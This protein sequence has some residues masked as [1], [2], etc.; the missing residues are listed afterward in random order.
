VSERA[1]CVGCWEWRE[2]R[3]SRTVWLGE[4]DCVLCSDCEEL[5]GPRVAEIL[6]TEERLALSLGGE[7]L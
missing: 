5:R 7:R 6:E 2:Y 1:L 4:L 3:Y